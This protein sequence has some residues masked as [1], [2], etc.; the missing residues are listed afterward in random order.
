MS[1]QTKNQYPVGHKP[2]AKF[3]IGNVTATVWKNG[4]GLLSAEIIRNYKDK[5]G[6]WKTVSSYSQADLLAV[7]KLAE[8]VEAYIAEHA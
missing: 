8:R 4:K 1:N 2:V 6:N 5:S 3:R 7:A